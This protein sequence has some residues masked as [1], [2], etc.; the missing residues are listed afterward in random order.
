MAGFAIGFLTI[1]TA[2]LFGGTV[3]GRR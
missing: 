1:T 3:T 2:A